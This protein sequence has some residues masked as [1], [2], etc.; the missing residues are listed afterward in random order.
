MD[1][2]LVGKLLF[3]RP[4][5]LRLC[6]WILH[7]EKER[8]FQSQPPPHVGLTS[9][10]TTELAKLV[11]L[12]MLEQE[13]PDAENRVYYVRVDSPLWAVIEAAEAALNT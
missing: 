11:R 3:G 2:T 7:L 9:A 10:V 6:I 12:G 13:R 8:F 4:T 1:D 5:R